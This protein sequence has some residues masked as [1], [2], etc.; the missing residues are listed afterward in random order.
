MKYYSQHVKCYVNLAKDLFSSSLLYNS[1]IASVLFLF[2][3]NTIVA[4]WDYGGFAIESYPYGM[5]EDDQ[6]YI[7]LSTGY[8]VYRFN[9]YNLTSFTTEHGLLNN[10][11]FAMYE[12]SKGR[13]WFLSQNK[14]LCYYENDTI[15]PYRAN[16]ALRK[17]LTQPPGS[18]YVDPH[19]TVW[20]TNRSADH[21]YKCWNDTAVEISWPRSQSSDSAVVYIKN[22]DIHGNI[23]LKY[24]DPDVSC[25][26]I[27]MTHRNGNF[28]ISFPQEERP[29]GRYVRA[30][31]LQ[32]G[33]ICVGVTKA[34]FLFDSTGMIACN[35]TAVPHEMHYLYVDKRGDIWAGTSSGAYRFSNGNILDP[36]PEVLFPNGNINRILQD[37]VGNYWFSD[38]NSGIHV[39][40]NLHFQT[41]QITQSAEPQHLPLPTFNSIPTVEITALH[42]VNDRLW[43]QSRDANLYYCDRDL[44]CHTVLDGS[45]SLSFIAESLDFLVDHNSNI[46][47]GSIL[48]IIKSATRSIQQ[49]NTG[50]VKRLLQ[51]ND[52]RVVV[53]HSNGFSIFNKNSNVL[54]SSH[55][56]DFKERIYA[57]YEDVDQSIW[58]GAV[59]GLYQYRDSAILYHGQRHPALQKSIG[60]I[61]ANEERTFF[62]VAT[63]S[64]LVIEQED[65]W[66]HLTTNDGLISDYV[67]SVLIENDSTIWATGDGLN[68][69]RIES[70][71]PFNY[72]ITT[73]G[74]KQG[75]PTE[76]IWDIEYFDNHLWL[77]TTQGLCRFD[78]RRLQKND[79]PPP[80]YIT[81]VSV[82]DSS[83]TKQSLYNLA[84][85]ENS[86]KISYNGISY[87]TALVQPEGLNHRYRL[88]GYQDDTLWINTNDLHVT[89]ASLPPGD[90]TFQVSAVNENGIWNPIPAQVRFHISP[91]FT[92]TIW[93]QLSLVLLGLSIAGIIAWQ[94]IK[95]QKRKYFLETQISELRQKMLGANMNPHFVFNSLSAIQD[96]VN[97]H[98]LYEANKFLSQ[99]SRLIRMNMN[100]SQ[101]SFASLEEELERLQ[102]YLSIE[103]LRFGD[104][105][106]YQITVDESID[107]DETVIPTMLLQPYVENAIWHGILPLKHSGNVEIEVSKTSPL[108]YTVEIRDNGVGFSQSEEIKRSKHTSLSMKLNKE[109]LKLL[110]SSTKQPFSIDVID[111]IDDS[112]EICGTVVRMVLPLE[113]PTGLDGF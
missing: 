68:R 52:N 28:R 6:G 35:P 82:N 47:T 10:T 18:L 92:D 103:K 26:D 67:Q 69:I 36:K 45:S 94:L 12:D 24:G 96:Y 49:T 77:A 19:D 39:F 8:G 105:L 108:T 51:L 110:S 86:I 70:W 27:N 46:W 14:E 25:R 87:R 61:T 112:G 23:A 34:L 13:I 57:L 98:D 84:Y 62:V 30:V 7:W 91:H 89:Y 29:I 22:I 53:G 66:H 1:L 104:R 95:N 100:A 109:R 59:S 44:L 64:G 107:Q 33:S 2:S 65:S 15:Q 71:E 58:L 75:L 111:R 56:L 76:E 42:V 32:D 17:I 80:I 113:I 41:Y 74:R 101:K 9:G 72:H 55:D 4:G 38:L 81:E 3:L 48:H 50:A 78:P 106:D 16:K 63:D 43:F 20:V 40:P 83:T 99:F 5:I 93:F 37:R 102:M 79:I 11:V 73:Y 97:Q 90:Y 54:N 88:L 31:S 60:D 21:L 85:N